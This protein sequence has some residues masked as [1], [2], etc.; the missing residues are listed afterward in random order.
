M[1]RR[2]RNGLAALLLGLTLVPAAA[3]PA[4]AAPACG[5]AGG[6]A[7]AQR[8]WALDRLAPESVWPLTRGRG[9]VV[10]VIDSG[11][12]AGHPLLRGQVLPGVDLGLPNHRGQCDEVGHGTLIGG[13]I[14]GRT[15][16]GVPYS[17]IAP[18]ARILPVR[19]LRDTARTFDQDLP[20]R[21]ATAIR[22]AVD[23]GAHVIN[24]SLVTVDTPALAEAV[25]YA[26]SKRVVLVAAAGNQS[27]QQPGQP[28]YPARYPGV[29]AVAG[30]DQQSGHVGSSVS[31]DYVDVAAPGLAIDGPA[32][33]GDGYLHESE[34][35]TSYATAYV[36]GVAA[37]VRSYHP[38]L[39]AEEVA[40]RI[41]RTS[42]A[43]P[44]GRNADVGYGVVNPY[45]AVSELLGTRTATPLGALPPAPPREDPLAWQRDAAIWTALLGLALALALLLFRPAARLG[46]SRGWRPGRRADA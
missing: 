38:Q 45:R 19:I 27:E 9:I 8:T 34:G 35:G 32:P 17:G 16:T 24:L 12:A 30:I 11:V 23:K 44:E 2:L 7:P 28:A 13:I 20:A 22:W 40:D 37:L 31:G 39:T 43:P 3:A 18:E 4:A 26:V 29:I 42:D 25:R 33:G 14:A 36:A 6:T 10:A 15:G 21:I 46:R 1:P 41:I 5:P